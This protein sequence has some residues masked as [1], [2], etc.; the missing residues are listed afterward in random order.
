MADVEED[1]AFSRLDGFGK[2]AAVREEAIA[3]YTTGKRIDT[4]LPWR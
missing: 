4:I 3:A 1:A 2:E